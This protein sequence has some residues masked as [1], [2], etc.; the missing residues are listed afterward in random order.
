MPLV[1]KISYQK[2]GFRCEIL[3]QT[4]AQTH[5]HNESELLYMYEGSGNITLQQTEYPL[6]TGDFAILL[7][8][9]SHSLEISPPS[10]ALF[11]M[12]DTTEFPAYTSILSQC[13][14]KDSPVVS[15]SLLHQELLFGVNEIRERVEIQCNH[16]IS[17]AYISIMLEHI[18]SYLTL[19]K[20][21]SQEKEPWLYELLCYLHEHYTENISL[22]NL[23]GNFAIS[24]SH[25]SRSFKNITG[26]TLIQYLHG[27]RVERAKYLLE[28]TEMQVTDITYECGFE[29]PSSFFRV[30]KNLCQISPNL[31]RQEKREIY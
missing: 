13:N 8:N 31:Y 3:N 12:F 22:E 1:D 17:K 18:L 28:Y 23:S 19:E 25:I 30:F 24:P 20:Q 26:Y 10:Q 9:I 21:D 2:W 14:V 4:V 6:K 11:V 15:A 5:M 27:L 16:N 29:S 7:P